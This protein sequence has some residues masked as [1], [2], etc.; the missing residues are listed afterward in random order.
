MYENLGVCKGPGRVLGEIK[1]GSDSI[2]I[3]KNGRHFYILLNNRTVMAAKSEKVLSERVV[4]VLSLM[5]KNIC[6]QAQLDAARWRH[7]DKEY[8]D[9]VTKTIKEI[10]ENLGPVEI[11]LLNAKPDETQTNRSILSTNKRGIVEKLNDYRSTLKKFEETTNELKSSSEILLRTNLDKKIWGSKEVMSVINGVK[12]DMEV[13]SNDYETIDGCL[14][15]SDDEAYKI[16]AIVSKRYATSHLKKVAGDI[17]ENFAILKSFSSEFAQV[18]Q[19]LNSIDRVFKAS[20]GYP[21]TWFFNGSIFMDFLFEYDNLVDHVI[22]FAALESDV[23]EPLLVWKI[24]FNG[25]K[26]KCPTI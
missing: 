24:K 16:Q 5:I 23:V 1:I 20:V 2:I 4:P 13:L 6:K 8:T 9:M 7:M 14:E 22:K 12:S 26:I 15:R 10:S 3:S 17:V 21:A 18:L 25:S 19:R 11:Y